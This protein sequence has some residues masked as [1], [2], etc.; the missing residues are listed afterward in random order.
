[1]YK[2]FVFHFFSQFISLKNFKFTSQRMED[3]SSRRAFA[4]IISSVFL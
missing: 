1:M 3:Y 2:Y 4:A